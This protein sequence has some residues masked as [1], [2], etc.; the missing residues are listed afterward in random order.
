MIN[1]N[2]NI[3]LVGAV[4]PKQ[5]R[6]I[7]RLKNNLLLC[8]CGKINEFEVCLNVICNNI[9]EIHYVND[10]IKLFKKITKYLI[11]TEYIKGN[12]VKYYNNKI[13]VFNS[14]MKSNSTYISFNEFKNIIDLFNTININNTNINNHEIDNFLNI[15]IKYHSIHYNL[16]INELIYTTMQP[17]FTRR[18]SNKAEECFHL[19]C[20][21]LNIFNGSIFILYNYIIST[22]GI[23][24]LENTIKIHMLDYI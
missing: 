6:R 2:N 11:N 7:L 23:T 10:N 19:N 12:T 18:I 16:T 13:Y 15:L 17:G 24:E 8:F 20:I 1:I 21:F 9:S 4:S 3:F 22:V 5:I 14:Y